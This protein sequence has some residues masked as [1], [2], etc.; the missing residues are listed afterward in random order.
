MST[1]THEATPMIEPVTKLSLLRIVSEAGVVFGAS[2]FALTMTTEEVGIGLTVVLA[3]I[4]IVV[5]LVRLEGRINTHGEILA[6][7]DRRMERLADHM[8]VPE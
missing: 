5:W 8:G 1:T 6:R 2:V 4:G 3:A 7:L